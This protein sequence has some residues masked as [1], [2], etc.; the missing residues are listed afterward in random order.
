[1]SQS[2][3]SSYEEIYSEWVPAGKFLKIIILVVIIISTSIVISISVFNP[4]MF[5][6]LLITILSLFVIIGVMYWNYRGLNIILTEKSIKLKYGIFN[7]KEIPYDKITHYE[8]TKTQFRKYGGIG[9]RL[10]ID[11]S[12]AYNTN[13]GEAI[14]LT[15]NNNRPFVFSTKHSAKILDI[16]ET[17]TQE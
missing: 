9:I 4:D 16:L 11:G 3:H 2:N 10:G 14:K 8:I 7:E 5:F 17:K 6:L 15:Y 13:F 12:R 1:M